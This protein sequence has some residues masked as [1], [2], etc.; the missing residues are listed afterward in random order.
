MP[1]DWPFNHPPTLTRL[2][3]RVELWRLHRMIRRAKRLMTRAERIGA[4][5]SARKIRYPDISH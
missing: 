3:H 4:R 5:T 2:W 1:S